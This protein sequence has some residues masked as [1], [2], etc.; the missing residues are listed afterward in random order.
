MA[1]VQHMIQGYCYELFAVRSCSI[2]LCPHSHEALAVRLCRL[3]CVHSPSC[4]AITHSKF[5]P[6]HFVA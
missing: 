1:T 2:V 6:R 3:Q 5:S 4:C